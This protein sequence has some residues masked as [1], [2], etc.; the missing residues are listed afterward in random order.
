MA[1]QPTA[2]SNHAVLGGRA[3]ANPVTWEGP[4]S[5]VFD[6]CGMEALSRRLQQWHALVAD[7]F[8]GESE[9]DTQI[10]ALS[11]WI[12]ITACASHDP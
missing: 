8:E 2:L 11:E 10:M 7:S 1:K 12:L 5:T 3:S 9:Y 4:C 6:R